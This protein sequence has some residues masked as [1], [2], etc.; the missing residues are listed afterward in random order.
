MPL[1]EGFPLILV[2]AERSKSY[3]KLY[4]LADKTMCDDFVF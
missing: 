2:E 4:L 3:R 1:N